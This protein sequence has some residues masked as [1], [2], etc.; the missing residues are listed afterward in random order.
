MAFCLEFDIPSEWLYATFFVMPLY[1][2]CQN[3]YYD[4]GNRLSSLHRSKLSPLS[5]SAPDDELNVYCELLCYYL[6]KFVFPFFQK[7]STPSKLVKVI[8]KKK[9]LAGP[10]FSCPPV[11]VSRL[12]LFSYLYTEDFKKISLLTK[13]YPHIIQ[14]STIFTEAVR[15]CYLKE[16]EAIAQL[17]Q[18]DVQEVR[19][20]CAQTIED[21]ILNC[22]G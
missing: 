10:F 11:Q 17:A 21:T 6:E 9:Y 14:D 19:A 22:F 4:Y 20:F 12:Q 7:I 18:K 5:K 15:N 16:N 1:I 3:R 13:K 8:E 2:P